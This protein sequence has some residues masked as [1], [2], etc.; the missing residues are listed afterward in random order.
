MSKPT[1]AKAMDA[2]R[3]RELNALKRE[4]IADINK[5]AKRLAEIK[6]EAD[7]LVKLTTERNDKRARRIA[8][9]ESRLS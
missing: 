6:R 9:L 2:L 4:S 3:R 1:H 7:R 8:I 5:T